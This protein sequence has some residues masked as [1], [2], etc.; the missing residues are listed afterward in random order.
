MD[1]SRKVSAPQKKVS[2]FLLPYWSG[3]IVLLEFR[4]PGSLLRIDILNISK[5]IAIEVS[6]DSIHRNFNPFM[7]KN[8]SEF[9]KKLKSDQDK[10]NWCEKS[11]IFMVELVDSD[12]ETLSV[13][14]FSV[15][16]IE[17]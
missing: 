9:L 16:G 17:L 3:D 4:I 5:K 15:K 11:G 13:E 14:T 7:H 2:D 8:R 6:P 10:I 12:I 1:W